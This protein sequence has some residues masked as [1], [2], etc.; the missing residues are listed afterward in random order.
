MIAGVKYRK[1]LDKFRSLGKIIHFLYSSCNCQIGV[2]K[3][4][5]TTKSVSRFAECVYMYLSVCIHSALYS[6]QY[7]KLRF[8]RGPERSF[9]SSLKEDPFTMFCCEES[10]GRW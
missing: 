4:D 6:S 8:C 1:S 2:F 10:K 5:S 7:P 9:E 3:G